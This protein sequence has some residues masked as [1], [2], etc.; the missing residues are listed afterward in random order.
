VLERLF[1]LTARLL[2]L[3]A[4][5]ALLVMM[6]LTFVDVIGRYGFHR[7]IFGT[8]EIVEYLMIFTIFA[9]LAFVT[10]TNDHITITMFDGWIERWLPNVR[11]WAVVLFSMGCYGLIAWHLLVHG[12]DLWASAKR[13][14]VLDLPLW[15]MAG[16]A[17]A[18]SAVGLV[19]IIL[20]TAKSRGHPERIRSEL[21]EIE[22][23]G[24]QPMIGGHRE[25]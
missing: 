17:G 24:A 23:G 22:A 2:A 7:S 13:S 8:A 6:V 12:Y 4:G 20:A 18:L 15:I 9:G 5:T 10:A 11:R 25:P 21:S 1:F 3:I 14:A 16:A 19:L